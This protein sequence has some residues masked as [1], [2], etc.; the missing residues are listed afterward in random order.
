MRIVFIGPPGAGKGTQCQRLTS[1][2]GIP[3]VSTGEMLRQAQR[4]RTPSGLAAE[5]YMKAGQ[6]AP[7][8]IILGLVERRLNE[9]DCT[10]GVLFDGFPR[11][12]HQARE[13]DRQLELA[14]RPL[15]LALE[16]VVDDQ[17][18]IRRLSSR[19]RPDDT[20]EIIGQRLKTYHDLTRPLLRYYDQSG[21]LA[22]VEGGGS[23]DE[24][25]E[26]IRQAVTGRRSAPT[27]RQS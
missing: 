23:P 13:L 27:R 5:R 19:G 18:V 11:T 3:H 15:D 14:G 16:L 1:L 22:S 6:L 24:V 20:A 17:L 12:L 7:D 21:R 26:R 25:F 9:P 10:A 4:E 2:L 8:E